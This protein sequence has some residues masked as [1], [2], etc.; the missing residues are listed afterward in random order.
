MSDI[1]ILGGDFEETA[2]RNR[3]TDFGKPKTSICAATDENL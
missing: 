2:I 1:L 3:A